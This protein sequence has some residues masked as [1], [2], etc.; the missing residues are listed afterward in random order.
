VLT[1]EN[2]SKLPTRVSALNY[3]GSTDNGCMQ[4]NDK[5]HFGTNGW[6]RYE[7][8]YNA[9]FNVQYALGIFLTRGNFS[10]WYSVCTPQHIS[11]IKGIKCN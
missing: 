4:I 9:D 10:A 8:I 7:D 5:A 11:K 1:L 3:D 6:L 2:G